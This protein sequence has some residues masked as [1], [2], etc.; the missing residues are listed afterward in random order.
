M[1]TT[2]KS[3]SK[4]RTIFQAPRRYLIQRVTRSTLIYAFLLL[5]CLIIILP[6]GWMLTVALKP[7]RLPVFTIPPEWYPTEHWEW[8]NF[9]RVL[10]SPN[11]P[12]FRYAL[13]TMV[14]VLGNLAG[15]ILSCSLVGFAFSRLRFRGRDFLFTVLIITMLIPWQVLMIPQFLMFHRIGWYGT[16]LPLIVPSFLGNAFYIFLIRQYMLTLPKELDEAA[17]IDGCNWF[18]TYFRIILPLSKPVLTVV[19]VFVFLDEW[20][21]LLGPLIY[22]DDGSKFTVAIGLANIATRADPSLNLVMA[23]NLLIMIPPIIIYFFAQERLIGGI[24]S[25][26]LKG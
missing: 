8:N 1:T 23:A 21:D 14:I 7:D 6:V 15:T 19:A 11:R 18:Q 16:Y 2:N 17:R 3:L 10:T 25:V 12:F 9:L 20:N 24:A 26:G 5:L 4:P 13:N 22:L